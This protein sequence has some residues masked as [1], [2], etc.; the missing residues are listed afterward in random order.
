VS[1]GASVKKG[2]HTDFFLH[3]RTQTHTVSA[4]IFVLVL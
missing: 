2:L 4:L 1:V 3:T